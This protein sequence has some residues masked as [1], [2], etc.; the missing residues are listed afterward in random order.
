MIE[1]VARDGYLHIDGLSYCI[2]SGKI[3]HVL[4]DGTKF[5]PQQEVLL[6][7]RPATVLKIHLPR[8]DG[9][10]SKIL[11]VM[12]T[13]NVLISHRVGTHEVRLQTQ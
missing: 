8:S 12:M 3:C 2:I 4:A 13:G 9:H 10:G 5:H 1:S 6:E 11:E 7:N